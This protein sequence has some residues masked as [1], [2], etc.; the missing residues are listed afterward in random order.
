MWKSVPI[1]KKNKAVMWLFPH[2]ALYWNIGAIYMSEEIE[3]SL[4]LF[5]SL[6]MEDKFK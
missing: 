1:K 6:K 2:I 4:Y 5:I 3:I